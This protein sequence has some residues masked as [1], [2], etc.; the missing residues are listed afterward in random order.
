LRAHYWQVVL[1]VIF[2]AGFFDDLLEVLE[3]DLAVRLAERRRIESFT[4]PGL[5][6]RDDADDVASDTFEV[7]QVADVPPAVSGTPV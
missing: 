6:P 7:G 3:Q 5:A 2:V 4:A 1:V